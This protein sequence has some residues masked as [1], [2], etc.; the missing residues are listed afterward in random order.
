MGLRI[1][2]AID[3]DFALRTENQRNMIFVWDFPTVLD[4]FALLHLDLCCG[5]EIRFVD[6]HSRSSSFVNYLAI[7][8][9][10]CFVGVCV[11]SIYPMRAFIWLHC[12]R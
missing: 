9:E 3:L 8:C 10:C 5:F 4:R 1:N 6:P 12:T 11:C 7:N 2:D